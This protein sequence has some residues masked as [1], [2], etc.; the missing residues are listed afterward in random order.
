MVPLPPLL[1]SFREANW[2]D[3]RVEVHG[4]MLSTFSYW[5][6]LYEV[7]FCG[8]SYSEISMF[9]E[10]LWGRVQVFSLSLIFRM[11]Q[12]PHY[13][14]KTFQ[15][16]MLDNLRNVAVPGTGVPLSIFCYSWW[17]CL[18]FILFVNPLV[19]LLGA[20]NKS[21]K[22]QGVETLDQFVANTCRH[23]VHHLL[24]P[25]DWFS[26]WRL[27]CRL[28]SYH[29]MVT[30]AIGYRQEDKWTFL[31][32]GRSGGVPVSPFMDVDAI[33]CKNKNIEGGM[34]IFFYKNAAHGGDWILQERM[35]NAAWLCALL[36]P[37]A[38]LSTMR[39]ITTSTWALGKNSNGI[40]S[41]STPYY[42]ETVSDDDVGSPDPLAEEK[43]E[44][45]PGAAAAAAGG[46]RTAT[47]IDSPCGKKSP[48]GGAA[49]SSSST[50]S[51]ASSSTAPKRG[52]FK[53]DLARASEFVT[54]R[55]AVLRLGRAGAATDHSSIL[56]DVD[57]A[58]GVIKEGATNAHWYH[59]GASAVR[60]CPWLP[61][62]TYRKHPD[63]PFPAVT[64]TVIPDMAEA[65]RIVKE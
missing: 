4:A 21:R 59:L 38:P 57:M 48:R 20:I 64:D 58:T 27:N 7:L 40:E 53:K 35:H 3:I 39:V 17:M 62:K 29:S 1:A 45:G 41:I 56:F 25:Q 10:D 22:M 50:T 12:R 5:L 36:P 28:V 31:V 61:Q 63:A 65:L 52:V 24:H 42:D 23:Y 49:S 37:N 47:W 9:K 26:L 19:C 44:R 11:W 15:Q 30:R 14:S 54:A 6:A 46:G 34:G 8:R 60:S 32:D 16:D 18:A 43:E 13:R 51:S 33:V 55:S 2:L